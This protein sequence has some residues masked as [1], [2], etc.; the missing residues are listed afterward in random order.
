MFCSAWSHVQTALSFALWDQWQEGSVYGAL[1]QLP[2]LWCGGCLKVINWGWRSKSQKGDSFHKEGR[3]SLCNN[4]VFCKWQVLLGIYC[5][6]FYWLP[7]FFILQLFH[8]LEVD[9]AK[10]ATRSVLMILPLNELFQKNFQVFY[11]T[12]DNSIILALV[13]TYLNGVFL[14]SKISIF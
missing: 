7:L 6:R 8:V 1:S 5:K 13:N 10:C 14:K 2:Y 11:F 12:P 4:A 9:K 3:F